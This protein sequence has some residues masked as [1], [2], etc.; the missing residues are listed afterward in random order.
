MVGVVERHW[1]SEL[2]VN[3]GLW[4]A[5]VCWW[6]KTARCMAVGMDRLTHTGM[7]AK[8]TVTSTLW[9]GPITCIG[10]WQVRMW[11]T[12]GPPGANCLAAGA[13]WGC[14]RDFVNERGY[15]ST[16]TDIW[17]SV[18]CTVQQAAARLP[19]RGKHM[20]NIKSRLQ[21]VLLVGHN[22]YQSTKNV[23]KMPAT[24]SLCIVEITAP[25]QIQHFFSFSALSLHLCRGGGGARS[26]LL[27]S[28]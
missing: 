18:C 16:V 25:G 7:I 13:E 23:L 21:V 4:S 9:P 11:I 10:L 17:T 3:C 5:Q 12:I 14:S 28:V 2:N 26:V 6:Q 27:Q 1:C 22:M 24:F 8:K 19:D 15:R 20:K